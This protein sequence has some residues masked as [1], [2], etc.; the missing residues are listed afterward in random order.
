MIYELYAK[1]DIMT[2]ENNKNYVDIINK[3]NKT[4]DKN[5]I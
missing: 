4:I 3:V 5:R 1:L 2:I